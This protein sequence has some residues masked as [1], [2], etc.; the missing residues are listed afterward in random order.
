MM[1]AIYSVKPPTLPANNEA[2]TDSDSSSLP[3]EKLL[4]LKVAAAQK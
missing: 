3:A 4:K 2:V 1:A